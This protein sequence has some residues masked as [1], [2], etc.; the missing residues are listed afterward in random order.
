MHRSVSQITSY[1]QCSMQYAL[2]RVL[3]VPE[4]PAWWNVGGS[5]VHRVIETYETERAQGEVLTPMHLSLLFV[6]EFRL[7]ISLAEEIEPDKSK[8]RAARSGKENGQWW[9]TSGPYQCRRYAER[10]AER[11]FEVWRLED[12]TP[13][14]ELEYSLDVEGVEVKGFIDAIFRYPNGDPLIRDVK[15]GGR[16]PD[17]TFQLGV[18]GHAANRCFGIPVR[19]AEFYMT[20]DGIS[21]RPGGSLGHVDVM[22]DHP[23]ESV[24]YQTL[25]MDRGER[26][27]LYPAKPSS[28]C[29]SCGVLSA[30]PVKGGTAEARQNFHK[31]LSAGLDRD[32]PTS[33]L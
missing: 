2:Q 25:T 11:E 30:C 16:K 4:R 9:L 21:G 29:S 1:N 28:L 20:R 24:V 19:F 7:G 31:I 15:S 6:E 8:W 32:A 23:W 5:A 22:A 33:S 3:K 13:A 27:G 10:E 18:Y 14:L 26:A 12:G 17:D